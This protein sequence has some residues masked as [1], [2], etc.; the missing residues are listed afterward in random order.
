MLRNKF[1]PKN[2]KMGGW[3]IDGIEVKRQIGMIYWYSWGKHE[4]D[5][6]VLRQVLHLPSEHQ[7]DEYFLDKSPYTSCS[8]FEAIMTQIL[9]N[10][11]SKSFEQLVYEHDILLHQIAEAEKQ[12]RLKIKQKRE[13]ERVGC[14]E[15]DDDDCPF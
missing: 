6:R 3:P 5:I 8:A 13:L 15:D 1:S 14:F 7:A 2:E 10:K 11:G 12:E 9:E 4:F